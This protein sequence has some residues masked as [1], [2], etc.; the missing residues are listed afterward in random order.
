MLFT[1]WWIKINYKSLNTKLDKTFDNFVPSAY[2]EYSFSDSKAL[3]LAYNRA[4]ER[5]DYSRLQPFEQK[6]SETSSYIG[7]PNLNPMNKDNA[8]LTYSYYGNVLT[9]ASSLFFNRY[10]DFWQD[11]TYETGE[12]INRINKIIRNHP[13]EI[14]GEQLRASMTAMKVIKTVV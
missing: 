3:S 2:L 11:V 12:Q 10:N 6:Y 4:I 9:I 1:Y 8:T 13:V 14:V 7:N 5:P